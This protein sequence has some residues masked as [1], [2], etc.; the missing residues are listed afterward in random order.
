MG[1]TAGSTV[2]ISDAEDGGKATLFAR[3]GVATL[4]GSITRPGAANVTT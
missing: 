2:V 1:K 4:E 3:S